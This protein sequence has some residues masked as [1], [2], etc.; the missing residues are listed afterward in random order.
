[1]DTDPRGPRA[2]TPPVV[3]PADYH[4]KVKAIAQRLAEEA[5]S[6]TLAERLRPD[7][8]EFRAIGAV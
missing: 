4:D 6:G 7:T 8:V 5:R 2:T 1:M 3:I